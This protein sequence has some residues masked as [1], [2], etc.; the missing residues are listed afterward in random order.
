MELNY[1]VSARVTI[2]Q[3][4]NIY[5]SKKPNSKEQIKKEIRKHFK[6]KKQNK[7]QRTKLHGM[8][9]KHTQRGINSTEVSISEKKDDIKSM[10]SAFSLKLEKEDQMKSNVGRRKEIIKNRNQ[11]NRKWK[12]WKE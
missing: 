2:T 11:R 7:I 9:V 1:K 12:K 3:K 8:E 10:T 4:A 6:L 5:T